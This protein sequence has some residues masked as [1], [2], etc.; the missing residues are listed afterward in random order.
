M[1]EETLRKMAES[2]AVALIDEEFRDFIDSIK[3]K[4]I[5]P[6]KRYEYTAELQGKSSKFKIFEGRFMNQDKTPIVIKVA[7]EPRAMFTEAYTYS[8]LG[9][10]PAIT[11]IYQIYMAQHEILHMEMERMWGSLVDLANI[12]RDVVTVDAVRN[13]MRQILAALCYLKQKRVIHGDL[14]PNNV[15]IGHKFFQNQQMDIKLCDFE[16]SRIVPLQQTELP[17][18]PDV[19]PVPYRPPE[20]LLGLPFSYPVDIFAAGCL[21]TFMINVAIGVPTEDQYKPLLVNEPIEAQI[22]IIDSVFG[23]IPSHVREQSFRA[24]GT[25]FPVPQITKRADQGVDH[26]YHYMKLH[27]N[28]AVN[29]AAGLIE[30]MTYPCSQVRILC[31]SA[32]F[33]PFFNMHASSKPKSTSNTTQST[34]LKMDTSI[35]I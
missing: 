18:S 13:I 22:Y 24:H 4:R 21:M 1:D 32:I 29:M 30:M 31:E 16:H 8:V 7:Q 10:H 26:Y 25:R 2:A 33:D 12:K 5:V 19:N 14:K 27:R 3:Q 28:P 20:I 23:P 34:R 6:E 11:N 15:L 35:S 17:F 9:I